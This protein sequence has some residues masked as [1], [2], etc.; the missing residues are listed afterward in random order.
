MWS[1][2]MHRNDV[3]TLVFVYETETNVFLNQEVYIK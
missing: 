1:I 3:Y 2:K